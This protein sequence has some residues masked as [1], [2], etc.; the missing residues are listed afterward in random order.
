[1]SPI[2]RHYKQFNR[3]LLQDPVHM[4]CSCD[5]QSGVEEANGQPKQGGVFALETPE[6]NSEEI[7]RRA[8]Q[9]TEDFSTWQRTLEGRQAQPP[10]A[11]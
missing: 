3:A 4:Q 2:Q 7:R 1:M 10:K 9:K 6:S 11:Q 8:T 5:E